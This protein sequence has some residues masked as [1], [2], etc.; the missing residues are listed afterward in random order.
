M[1][2]ALPLCPGGAH[3]ASPA[4]QQASHLCHLAWRG[5]L[6]C[7]PL[8]HVG[9]DGVMIQDPVPAPRLGAGAQAVPLKGR[10]HCA[11]NRQLVPGIAALRFRLCHEGR[12]GAEWVT[13]L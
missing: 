9:E 7:I 10:E 5:E 1:A 6:H 12:D 2:R 4:G 11:D 8:I 13:D 3:L